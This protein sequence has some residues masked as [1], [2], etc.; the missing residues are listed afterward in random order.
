MT[1]TIERFRIRVDDSILEDL[2]L[3]LALSRFPDQIEGT[4]WSYGTPID[5]VRELV[6]Y[7]RN[8]YDWRTHETSSR[9][10]R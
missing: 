1:E 3:R 7:W 9:A 10:I 8:A 6:E 5:Y 2:R 4:G